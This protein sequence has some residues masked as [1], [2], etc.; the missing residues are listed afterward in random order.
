MNSLKDIIQ[1]CHKRRGER[2]RQRKTV[3]TPALYKSM[4]Y[5]I[6]VYCAR[7][8]PIVLD[9][10]EQANI[11]F[12]PIGHAPENDRGPRDFGGDRFFE[13]QGIQDWQYRRWYASWGIQI[14]T[15]IPSERGGA[16]WHDF[17]FKYEAIC[18]APD[19]V[20]NCIEALLKTTANP[21]LTLTKS[22]GLRFSCR[23]PDY[24]HPDTDTAKSYIY[25][26]T[27]IVENLHNRDVYLEIRGEKGYSR[28]D[29]RYEILYGNLIAPPVIAKELLFIPINALRTALHEPSPLGETYRE[30]A[31]IAPP[32]LG[33]T[34][35]D[36]AKEAFLERGYDYIRQDN[37]F[38]H[39]IRQGGEDDDTYVLLWE[40]Q[41][42]VWVRSS[43]P[44]TELPTRAVPITEIWNDTGITSPVSA[45]GLPLSDDLLAVREGK[46]SP[47][48]IKRSPPL[49]YR[50]EPSKKAYPTLKE[51]ATQ[52]RSIFEK[53]ARI[54]GITA[55]SVLGT[56]SE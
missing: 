25:K 13:R 32:S 40:D 6:K 10:L 46:L 21:L 34:N 3:I 35:L 8:T 31:S 24:L 14:Y 56:I 5:H 22:G 55:E 19:A 37:S 27:P 43:T 47:L 52:I 38:H 23:V 41:G 4:P 29:S 1:R 20:S 12:M 51:Q 49:L 33:S 16:R 15:G 30:T 2:L 9:D 53:E 42:I 36:F 17:D 18:A 28:W 7:R 45:G 48:A 39:W 44:N 11:S 26:H 50:Q 54:I